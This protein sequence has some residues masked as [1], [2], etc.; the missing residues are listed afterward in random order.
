MPAKYKILIWVGVIFGL[1]SFVRPQLQSALAA[2]TVSSRVI[3]YQ[4]RLTDS[5]GN[6]VADGTYAMTFKIYT[7]STGG[8]ASFTET[9]S[10]GNSVTV[11]SGLF[12]VLL[13]SLSANGVNLDFA[14]PPYYLGI[15]IASNSEMSPRIQLGFVPLAHN[16]QYIDRTPISSLVHTSS[17]SKVPSGLIGY[18][19]TTC[20]TGWTEY[21]AARGRVVV[22]TPLSGTNAGT[23]GTAYT[24]LE[25]RTHT[26][27]P[28]STSHSHTTVEYDGYNGVPG[29][30]RGSSS[31]T[32]GGTSA[33]NATSATPPYI[34]LTACKKD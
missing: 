16:A 21:T 18:F 5:S 27:I 19:A 11:T 4:G 33:T 7:V 13:G 30:N 2:I 9:F 23:V 3:P 15:T 34:Q 26:H 20:P 32:T 1:L 25:D 17:S 28:S 8:S 31:A 12:S 10:A 22:G 14:N 29:E 6:N 24:N